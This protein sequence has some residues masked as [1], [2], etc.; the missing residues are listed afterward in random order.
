MTEPLVDDKATSA[1]SVESW[2]TSLERARTQRRQGDAHS[3]IAATSDLLTQPLTT[4][5]RVMALQLRAAALGDA[6]DTPAKY[7]DLRSALSSANQADLPRWVVR[8]SALAAATALELGH[9]SRALDHAVDALVAAQDPRVEIEDH[10]SAAASL[11]SLFTHIGAPGVS[12][13]SWRARGAVSSPCA[14]CRGS[15]MS[16]WSILAMRWA[17]LCPCSRGMSIARQPSVRS[18]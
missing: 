1:A 6:G 2:L 18:R 16:R 7:A 9:V 3:A 15:P 11:G 5:L 12:A 14:S 17:R 8:A 13:R 4:D 10:L